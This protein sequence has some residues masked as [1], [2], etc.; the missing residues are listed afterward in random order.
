MQTGRYW[1]IP[2]RVSHLDEA[3]HAATLRE[4]FLDTL[5]HQ[6]DPYQRIGV[7]LSGGLDSAV[8]AAGARHVVGDRELHTFTAGYGEDDR[9]LVNAAMVARELGT[10]HH[11]LVLSPGDLPGLLPW[12]VWHLEE[13]IGREDIAYLFV[14][15]REAARHVDLV[16]AGFGFDGLFAGLP[17]H[18]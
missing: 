17:R 4:S 5:Q 6:T 11:P 15:A 8:M 12:M 9:E 10:R 2:V 3:R 7:S 1:D 14:T 16:L 13:P 18:R